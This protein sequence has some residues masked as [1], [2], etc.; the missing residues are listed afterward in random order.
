LLAAALPVHPPASL[1]QQEQGRSVRP[2]VKAETLVQRR[3]RFSFTL[4][5]ERAQALEQA[6]F[7]LYGPVRQTSHQRLEFLDASHPAQVQV[8]PLGNQVLTFR[9][10]P[11]APYASR[12]VTID[13]RLELSER[14][15]PLPAPDPGLALFTRAERFIES[16]SPRIRDIA[17]TLRSDAPMQ[18]AHNS[19]H[20]VRSSL[21]RTGFTPEDRGALRA[22][23][24]KAG[25]CTEHAY[26]LAALL[27]ANGI[28]ARVMGGYL[29]AE[30]GLV[31]PHDY[32]NWVE[33]YAEGAWRIADAHQANFARNATRYLATRVMSAALTPAQGATHPL[34]ASHRYAAAGPGLRV[35][36][37]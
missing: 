17:R 5:N 33:F 7:S 37:N 32:H 3:V 6:T 23:V 34:G 19:Y 35:T 30:S 18:T 13:A 2:P 24:D 31:R 25:D 8:D 11:L 12:V 16:D 10:E 15:Q 26:L 36:M 14:A 29:M 9:L 21:G 20:W 27:R 4:H 28:P 22:L 1:A